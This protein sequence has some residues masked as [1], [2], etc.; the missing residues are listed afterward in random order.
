MLGSHPAERS[1]FGPDAGAGQD[2]GRCGPLLRGNVRRN[3]VRS[4]RREGKPV[5]GQSLPHKE[6]APETAGASGEASNGAGAPGPR[7]RGGR[8]KP[9][10]LHDPPPGYRPP[11]SEIPLK[12]RQRKARQDWVLM[13]VATLVLVLAAAALVVIIFLIIATHI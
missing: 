3:C 1:P 9:I 6:P 5:R 10:V 12:D 2:Q 13:R 11:G 7:G 8:T 4:L